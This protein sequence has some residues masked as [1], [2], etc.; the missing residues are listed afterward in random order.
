MATQERLDQVRQNL[1][2]LKASLDYE[3]GIRTEQGIIALES[4]GSLRADIYLDKDLDTLGAATNFVIT[5]KHALITIL[6]S[7]SSRI[8]KVI[9][10]KAS[11]ELAEWLEVA[12][13]HKLLLDSEDLKHIKKT[14]ISLL[15]SSTYSAAMRGSCGESLKFVIKLT[16]PDLQAS[17]ETVVEED[18]DLF[19]TLMIDL[20]K[21]KATESVKVKGVIMC[22]LGALKKSNDLISGHLGS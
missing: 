8:D 12:E 13:K 19:A 1:E 15:R 18:K 9:K 17:H 11:K 16:V 14:C 22:I 4:L 10:E 6:H 7:T 20:I 3:D 2:N 21:A 5:E